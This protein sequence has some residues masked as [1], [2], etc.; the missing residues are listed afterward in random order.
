MSK[1][2]GRTQKR[3]M[4]EKIARLEEAYDREKSLLEW[5]SSFRVKYQELVDEFKRWWDYSILLPAEEIEVGEFPPEYRIA[6]YEPLPLAG[7]SKFT[8]IDLHYQ[9]LEAIK[10]SVGRALSSMTMHVALYTP[11]GN[12]MIY[13]SEKALYQMGGFPSNTA[14]MVYEQ[15]SRALAAEWRSKRTTM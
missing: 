9:T 10:I 3:K 7:T 12:R 14:R 15:L 2:F 5:Y 11:A 8:E 4:R 13:I 1:R 6:Q